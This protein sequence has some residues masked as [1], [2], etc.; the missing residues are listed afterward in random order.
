MATDAHRGGH[1]RALLAPPL[2]ILLGWLVGLLLFD[3]LGAGYIRHFLGQFVR[4]WR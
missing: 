1:V 4:L 2:V 3:S